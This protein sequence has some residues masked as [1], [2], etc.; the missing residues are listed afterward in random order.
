MDP[1]APAEE[2]A[3]DGAVVDEPSQGA[4]HRRPGQNGVALVEAEI[5]DAR[6]RRCEDIHAGEARDLGDLVGAEIARGVDIAAFEEQPLGRRFADVAQ[7]DALEGHAAPARGGGRVEEGE[8]AGPPAF[9]DERAAARG[10][11]AQPRIAPVGGALRGGNGETV[12]HR[13]DA[14]AQ[15]VAHQRRRPGA[16]EIEGETPVVDGADALGREAE[17]GE[18]ERRRPGEG[19]RPAQREHY[20]S[21]GDRPAACEGSAR[22]Q[23]EDEARAVAPPRLHGVA[24]GRC[25]VVGVGAEQP[26]VEVGDDLGA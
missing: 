23:G 18:D 10:V 16:V 21:G 11:R 12:D 8:L 24:E 13:R 6:P 4:A 14:G 7:G 26:R 15:R 9:E 5:T 20:V 17:L 25:G 1:R 19:E 22:A 2:S 3:G